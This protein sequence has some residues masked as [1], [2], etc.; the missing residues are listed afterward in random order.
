[1]FLFMWVYS[2]G[3]L[4]GFFLYVCIEHFKS[5]VFKN[6]LNFLGPWI[7]IEFSQALHLLLGVIYW[8]YCLE[9][10]GTLSFLLNKSNID[11]GYWQWLTL[12]INKATFSSYWLLIGNMLYF[13]N[14]GNTTEYSRIRPNTTEYSRI[15]PNTTKDYR[16]TA[17]YDRIRPNTT[18]YSRI[19]PNIRPNTTEYDRIRPNRPTTEYSRI[20][21]NTTKYYRIGLQLNMTEYDQILPNTAE[22]DRIRPNTAEYDRV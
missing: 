10:R 17:E 15:W 7:A 2:V 1:M 19:W 8:W 20:W 16:I 9:I 4:L 3:V 6:W 12:Y 22:Y 18:E 13:L 11:C 5:K 14:K 21:P